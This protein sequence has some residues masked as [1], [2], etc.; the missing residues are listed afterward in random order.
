MTTDT[1]RPVCVY[2][3]AALKRN[4]TRMMLIM[5]I[6]IALALY[7]GYVANR[8]RANSRYMPAMSAASHWLNSR[9]AQTIGY[10]MSM[11]GSSGNCD[12]RFG[13]FKEVGRV[14]VMNKLIK[15]IVAS[16]G[17]INGIVNVTQIILLKVY[18]SSVKATDAIIGLSIVGLVVS[19]ICLVG[20]FFTCKMMCLS[21]VGIHH[22][23]II[24]LGMK[25]RQIQYNIM[26]PSELAG[27]QAQPQG[28]SSTAAAATSS[29]TGSAMKSTSMRSSL[30]G[31][32][33]MPTPGTGGHVKLSK[34][35]F[36]PGH[37]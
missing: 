31:N 6:G 35:Q 23:L 8:M 32:C 36:R 34:R 18:C 27:N 7:G 21:C 13:S 22:G 10:P 9:L 17:F 15:P 3:K 4:G 29:S 2:A 16:S 25:R 37:K 1:G 30:S 19:I 33:S 26:C 5:C 24:Y 12:P 14:W 20:S 11:F 28:S